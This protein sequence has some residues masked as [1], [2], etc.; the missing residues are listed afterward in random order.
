[1]VMVLLLL[2]KKPPST[3]TIMNSTSRC[4]STCSCRC[5]I[6]YG[7]R[8]WTFPYFLIS[9]LFG[10]SRNSL[11]LLGVRKRPNILV[12][13]VVFLAFSRT[14]K[15]QGK[16]MRPFSIRVGKKPRKPPPKKGILSFFPLSLSVSQS[17]SLSPL[18][19]TGPMLG[20]EYGSG[21]NDFEDRCQ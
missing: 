19:Y 11:R 18:N 4:S 10:F 14:K 3:I 17:L 13:L 1:M 2:F 21:E 15:K 9:L 5:A 7:Y 12:V 16:T 20:A 8:A 6:H